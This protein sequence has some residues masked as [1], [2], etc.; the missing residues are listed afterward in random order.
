MMV[1]F[2]LLCLTLVLGTST[3]AS[4]QQF[5]NGVFDESSKTFLWRN[6]GG[7]PLCVSPEEALA[8]PR[9]AAEIPLHVRQEL[10]A[11]M[12]TARQGAPTRVIK[13]GDREDI[14]ISGCNDPWI[15]QNV[16]AQPSKWKDGRSREAW[17]VYY[18]DPATGEQ[19]RMTFYE[20]CD[21]I[22]VTR[23]GAPVR[24]ICIEDVDACAAPSS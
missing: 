18:T 24:C 20:V 8:L 7:D 21:N 11:R 5:P 3:V 13:D 9:V 10:L 12:A 1:R 16:V 4:A 15:A 14:M 22:T 19:W 17:S 23:I 6:G 2:L